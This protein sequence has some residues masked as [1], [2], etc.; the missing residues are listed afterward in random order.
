MSGG[1]IGPERRID[2]AGRTAFDR[3]VTI[4]VEQATQNVSAI[5]RVR[6]VT[7]AFAAAFVVAAA[8]AIAVVLVT[9]HDESENARHEAL[10]N[11][12]L[13]RAMSNSVADF[14]RSD[15]ELRRKQQNLAV[16]KRLLESLAKLIPVGLLSQSTQEANAIQV[17]ITNRWLADA[18]ALDGIAGLDCPEK[19][20]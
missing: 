11:C 18:K 16:T 5:H 7:Q 19:I 1:Y 14:V 17:Q 10:V 3:A 6:L 13:V 12:Q 8:I 4:A 15:A 2:L 9:Q 20:S